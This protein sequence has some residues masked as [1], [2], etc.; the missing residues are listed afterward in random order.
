MLVLY[1]DTIDTAQAVAAMVTASQSDELY[2]EAA[3]RSAMKHANVVT[4][5]SARSILYLA[6][7]FR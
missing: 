5:N 4:H 7:G 1:D 6:A 2:Y 3:D